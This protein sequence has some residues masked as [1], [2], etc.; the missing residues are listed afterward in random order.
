MKIENLF[1]S[2]QQR[3][4]AVNYDTL[5]QFIGWMGIAL[6]VLLLIF[7]PFVHKMHEHDKI[8]AENPVQYHYRDLQVAWYCGDSLNREATCQSISACSNFPSYNCEEQKI[9]SYLA[10]ISNY[11]QFYMRDIFVGVL[12]ILAAF[13]ITYQGESVKENI[14]SSLA[15]IC[16]IIV[17]LAPC[18]D[19]DFFIYH[20]VAAIGLFFIFMLFCFSIFPNAT[21]DHTEDMLLPLHRAQRRTYRIC[22]TIILICLLTCGMLKYVKH[23]GN[24]VFWFESLMLWAFGIS[25]LA[26]GKFQMAR[27][28]LYLKSE[29]IEHARQMRLKNNI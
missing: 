1:K 23:E 25:W 18:Y 10:T 20:Y 28:R 26:S 15:G 2:R 6:P 27:I 5:R 19:K 12:F 16:A 4:H 14:L 13:L 3:Q 8:N 29:N 9:E 11:H 17:A 22:G 24:L 7:Q 21:P